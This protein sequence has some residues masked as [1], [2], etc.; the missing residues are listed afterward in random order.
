VCRWSLLRLQATSG[1]TRQRL[2][3]IDPKLPADRIR[4]LRR[5]AGQLAQ[6]RVG[7]V[8]ARSASGDPVVGEGSF[9]NTDRVA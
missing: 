3:E 9:V 7:S 5:D 8:I 6:C 1:R 2:W 4:I